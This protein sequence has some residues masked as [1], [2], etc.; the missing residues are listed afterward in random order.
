MV[1]LDVDRDDLVVVQVE[2]GD[3]GL[4]AVQ[5]GRRVLADQLAGLLVV[6]GVGDVDGARR[7]GRS[8]ERDDEQPGVLGLA[9]RR[10]DRVAVARDQDALVAAG[11]RVVD[12]VDL[13]LRVT[14]C[15]PAATDSLTLSFL[16]SASAELRIETKYGLV[17]VLRISETPT[18]PCL[19][20]ER[21]ATSCAAT[22]SPTASQSLGRRVVRP[23]V[24]I[25]TYVSL[26]GWADQVKRRGGA[27][28]RAGR[29]ECP[30]CASHC[31]LSLS[32]SAASLSPRRRPHARC[33]RPAVR[34]CTCWGTARSIPG[35]TSM[36]RRLP[37]WPR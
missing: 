19:N 1:A 8:V 35:R 20:A 25:A 36:S 26:H 24:R 27:V 9:Q 15:L 23:D 30:A 6:G 3:D 10:V 21:H 33:G 32:L 2:H 11:D 28:G 34:R 14:V 7:D 17:S 37:A 5:L 4:L 16:A 31:S 29:A 12:G 13:G 22:S 18:S